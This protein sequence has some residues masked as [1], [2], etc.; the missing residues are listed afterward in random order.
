[1]PA[2]LAATREGIV[3]IE[4]TAPDAW[5]S[6]LTLADV[7]VRALCPTL[8]DVYAATHGNGVYRS[9][10]G[11]EGWAA[12]G[13]EGQRVTALAAG[14]GIVYAGTKQPRVHATRDGGE[15]WAPL[16]PFPRHRSWWW[17]QPAEPPFH[18]SFVS[19]L[20]VSEGTLLAGI[21]ACGV[22]RS[23]D[24]GS[25]WSGHRRGALRDCHELTVVGK[26]IYEAGS[27]GLAASHDGGHRWTRHREGLDR[28]YGWAVA[29]CEE[30]VYLV[31]GTYRSAHSSRPRVR[32]FRSSSGAS[33]EP[34][35]DELPR[36]A[37]LACGAPGELFMALGDGSLLRSA[38]RGDTW[39]QL[40]VQL[41]MPSRALVYLA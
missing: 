40:P 29:A 16:A 30:V 34:C 24:G 5:T 10:D 25:T 26:S 36:L 2:L 21:E 11:G 18:P 1:V 22:L 12:R 35:G 15:T 38:D 8:G 31:V 14:D 17:I 41:R 32:L 3:R 7:D 19:A 9:A 33:W 39:S 4:R 28:R 23:A 20:A 27:G 6:R 37:K 13:L